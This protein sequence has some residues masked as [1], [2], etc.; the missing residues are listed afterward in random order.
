MAELGVVESAEE[1]AHHVA[2]DVQLLV[3]QAVL[4]LS[5]GVFR[6]LEHELVVEQHGLL[7]LGQGLFLHDLEDGHDVLRAEHLQEEA[8][9]EH[10]V[11]EIA[12]LESE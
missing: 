1:G 5:A 8:P 7:G 4:L 6:D 11:P 9:E 3:H 12:Q 2:D 10:V